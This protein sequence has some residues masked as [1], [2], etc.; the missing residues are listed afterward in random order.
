MGDVGVEHF[1][2][3]G[4]KD[5]RFTGPDGEL[6]GGDVGVRPGFEQSGGCLG[7]HVGYGLLPRWVQAAP[8]SQQSEETLHLEYG[9]AQF[10]VLY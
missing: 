5:G 2:A 3:V 7:L 6:A 9:E 8:G 10:E 4:C 1:G